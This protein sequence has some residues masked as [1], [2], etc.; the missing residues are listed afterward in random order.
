M[1]NQYGVPVRM[2]F[3]IGRKGD[4]YIPLIL[5]AWDKGNGM[6]LLSLILASVNRV[7]E[8]QPENV[9][10]EVRCHDEFV[11]SLYSKLFS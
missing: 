3:L 6:T 2:A 10:I 5:Y 7:L 1:G 4:I 8:L 9:K 11:E